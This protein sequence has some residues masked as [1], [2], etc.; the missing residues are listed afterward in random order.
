MR[1]GVEGRGAVE[2]ETDTDLVTV[3]LCT[4]ASR[5]TLADCLASLDALDDPRHEILVVQNRPDPV[6]EIEIGSDRPNVRV[7]HEPRRGLDVARNRGV[8]EAR[9][10]IVAFID[11][12]CIADPRWLRGLRRA[13]ADP[14]VAFVAGRA[15]AWSLSNPSERYFERMF[16]FDRSELA[17][18]FDRGSPIPWLLVCPGALGTGCNMA[19]RRCVFDD[20]GEFDEALDMGTL[21]SGGG[22][23]DMFARLLRAGLRAR[24]A[25]DAVVFHRH[26]TDMTDLAWQV[27]GYGLSQGAITVKAWR[28]DTV[29][30]AEAMVFIRYRIRNAARRMLDALRGREAVPVRLSVLELAGI[31]AG[32]VV[33]PFAARGARTAAQTGQHGL[34]R[35]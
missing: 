31:V 23:L 27:W 25:P 7:V 4:T 34:N 16:S 26:R 28:D 21:I 19:F 8:R 9:G 20:H 29:S 30:R 12:D 13:F 2:L 10:S 32:V 17:N 15:P 18:D 35:A 33:Y 14:E 1:A 3:V 22:D 11:D 6:I 24:Y 5:A